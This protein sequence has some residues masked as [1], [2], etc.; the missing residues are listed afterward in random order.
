M[1]GSCSPW[2]TWVREWHPTSEWSNNQVVRQAFG[3]SELEKYISVLVTGSEKQNTRLE[4]MSSSQ[5]HDIPN[6]LRDW[7]QTVW[8]GEALRNWSSIVNDKST[9]IAMFVKSVVQSGW[10]FQ[11][12]VPIS[13][14][15]DSGAPRLVWQFEPGYKFEC[16][17]TRIHSTYPNWFR[18]SRTGSA[19]VDKKGTINLGA[20]KVSGLASRTGGSGNSEH[21]FRTVRTGCLKGPM[22]SMAGRAPQ[23]GSCAT[24]DKPF[25]L[26]PS[27]SK[28]GLE[29]IQIRRLLL[30][31]KQLLERAW[32]NPTRNKWWRL[33]SH[34][35]SI[36]CACVLFIEERSW[37]MP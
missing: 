31:N 32:S 12:L 29:R 3:G 26:N 14:R 13:F 7:F 23:P 2:W 21:G 8:I 10:M 4:T 37:A 5:R 16:M 20:A 35:W 34:G 30:P 9:I 25:S 1:L 22:V 6:G 36:D 11:L 17:K 28:A 27:C 15:P 18:T 19:L 33:D 24:S